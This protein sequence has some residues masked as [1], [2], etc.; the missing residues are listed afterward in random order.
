[1]APSSPSISNQHTL[2]EIIVELEA[3]SSQMSDAAAD[4]V[5][6][7]IFKIRRAQVANLLVALSTKAQPVGLRS[8]NSSGH[9][10]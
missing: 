7:G 5:V 10:L 6:Q 1:M 8:F 3:A 2:R 9:R 4:F